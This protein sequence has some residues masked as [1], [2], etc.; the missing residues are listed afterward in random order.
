M[1]AGFFLGVLACGI[2]LV[3]LILGIAMGAR[4]S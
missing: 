3:V 2:L 1:V 4:S